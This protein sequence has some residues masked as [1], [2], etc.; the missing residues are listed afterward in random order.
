MEVPGLG[1]GIEG[2]GIG[3]SEVARDDFR[4]GIRKDSI[5]GDG[6]CVPRAVL[7]A[8][9][10][11]LLNCRVGEKACDAGDATG[12]VG[13]AEYL[14]EFRREVGLG[15]FCDIDNGEGV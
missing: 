15:L 7:D 13:L 5:E 3:A 10:R 12:D 6:A 1:G 2:G 9:L 8:A 14:V 11:S 4:L